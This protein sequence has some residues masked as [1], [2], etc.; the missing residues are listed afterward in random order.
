MS[1]TLAPETVHRAS[2]KLSEYRKLSIDDRIELVQE[3]WDSIAEETND[4]RTL[5]E[6]QKRELD[7]SLSEHLQH[8]GD[9]QTWDEVRRELLADDESVSG[10]S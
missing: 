10:G 1:Q 4:S 8:P 9:V 7:H 3:I 5:P 6:W 2:L